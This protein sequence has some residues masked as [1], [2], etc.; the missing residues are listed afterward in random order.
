[1]LWGPYG[2]HNWTLYWLLKL[3]AHRGLKLVSHRGRS[4][5]DFYGSGQIPVLVNFVKLLVGFPINWNQFVATSGHFGATVEIFGNSKNFTAKIYLQEILVHY[6]SSRSHFAL[7]LVHFTDLHVDFFNRFWT[8]LIMNWPWRSPVVAQRQHLVN[9]YT[10]WMFIST[11]LRTYH[12][13][14]ML[15]HSRNNKTFLKM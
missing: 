2:E 7:L 9:Q 6:Q 3:G 8:R 10:F 4:E 5:Y 11:W 14:F 15:K 12:V 13:T 1:M